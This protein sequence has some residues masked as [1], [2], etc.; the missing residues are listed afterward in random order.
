MKKFILLTLSVLFSL[1]IFT[2]P[3]YAKEST[4]TAGGP[5]ERLRER[6]TEVKGRIDQTKIDLVKK[7]ATLE[8]EVRIKVLN[9]LKNRINNNKHLAA[10]DKTSLIADIDTNIS[11]LN[12]LKA[13]IEADTDIEVLR[14]DRQSIYTNFR[15]FAVVIPRT[16]G[17]IAAYEMEFAASRIDQVLVKIQTRIDQAKAAGKDVT[18]LNN[19]MTDAK[20]KLADAKAKYQDAINQFKQ[21]TASNYPDGAKGFLEAGRNDLKTGKESLKAVREDISKM[22]S[23]LKGFNSAIKP[24]PTP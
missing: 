4:N 19:L 2:L 22:V 21:A 7:K 14:T 9:A 11:G 1:G 18:G 12:T 8:I 16:R 15:I 6:K 3:V 10:A 20:N 23:T 17:Q 24:S 5:F 13:K